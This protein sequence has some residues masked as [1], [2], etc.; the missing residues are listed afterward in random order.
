MTIRQRLTLYWAAVL[1]VILIIAACSVF[2]IFRRQ[3]WG[4]LDAALLEEADTSA[5]AIAHA[6]GPDAASIV[7][8]LSQERDI[9]PGKRVR[10]VVGNTVMADS[11]NPGA[12][13]PAIDDGVARRGVFDGSRHLYRFAV[14]PLTIGDRQAFI[15]DGVDASPVRNSIARLQ[16]ILL[17][18]TPLLLLFSVAGGYWMAGRSLAPVNALAGEL[19][20][21]DPKQLRRR[22]PVGSAPDEVARL[23]ASIN[24]LLDRLERASVTERRF[25]GDAAHELRTPLTVL[26]TGLEIALNR[27]RGAQESREALQSA[28]RDVVALCSTAEELLTLARLSEE[29]FEQRADI[30]LSALVHEAAEAVEPLLQARHL[31]L[32]NDC[33]ARVAVKGNRDHLRRLVIN[34]LDNAIKFTPENGRVW[35]K[36]DAG[37][38]RAVLRV[39]DSGPGIAPPDLPFIFDRFFR[40]AGQKTA[41]SGLGLSLCKEIVRLHQ[42]EIAARNIPQGGC[43]FVVTLPAET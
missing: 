2:V 41:G 22:L 3:Q 35:I 20:R 10:L 25:L 8:N 23:A 27:E 24:A 4:A 5:G 1:A 31:T 14:M 16:T 19:A 37:Q 34:L 17:F 15:E 28:L 13:L 29:A 26:R 33:A 7:R 43:E 11:G 38:S 21:I 42:G 39:S 18:A 12:D 32:N 36:L 6:E 30:D 9:G 40:A